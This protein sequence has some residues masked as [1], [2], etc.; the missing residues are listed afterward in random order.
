MDSNRIDHLKR[1]YEIL[2][3]LKSDVVEGY[4]CLSKCNKDSGWPSHGVYFFMEVGEERKD[5]G[6][7]LRVV[8]VGTHSVK[9][10]GSQTTLW[11]RLKTHKGTEAGGGNSGSSIFRRL[12]GS[13]LT[14]KCDLSEEELES[15]EYRI[16]CKIRSMP[17]L[18]LKVNGGGKG[19]KDR[20]F[21]EKNSIALLSNYNRETKLDVPSNDWLGR[22]CLD[23]KRRQNC[24]V[25]C[26]GLW[27]QQN[28]G[29][30]YQPSFLDKLEEIVENM[31]NSKP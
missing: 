13:A 8:R 2:D 15:L 12:V 24:K 20:K 16:S 30:K 11:D 27:N 9:Q 10:G 17:F 7:G 4:R 1:F 21:I 31:K 22:Y 28:V 3:Y 18:W 6:K 19:P 25:I 14:K 26:S 5:S 29:N 23:T